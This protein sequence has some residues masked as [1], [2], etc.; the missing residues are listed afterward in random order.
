MVN[1]WTRNKDE[2]DSNQEMDNNQNEILNILTGDNSSYTFE[3]N[4]STNQLIHDISIE[5]FWENILKKPQT[6]TKKTHQNSFE[7]IHTSDIQK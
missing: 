2:Q 3:R 7:T 1:S 4:N 5:T 6:I